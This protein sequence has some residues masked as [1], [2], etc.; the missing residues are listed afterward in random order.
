M[1]TATLQTSVSDSSPS[2]TGSNLCSVEKESGFSQGSGCHVP[3]CSSSSAFSISS[4]DG[5]RPE[6]L[7]LRAN[8]TWPSAGETMTPSSLGI[9]RSGS[10]QKFAKN[11]DIISIRTPRVGATP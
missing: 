8:M 11:A 9:G 1:K 6:A 4:L 2:G 10:L 3:V 7:S 5:L